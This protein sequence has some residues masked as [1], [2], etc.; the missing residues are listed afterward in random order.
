MRTKLFVL[1]A[2]M[3]GVAGI[4]QSE[5]YQWINTQHVCSTENAKWTEAD[6]SAWGEWTNSPST[7]FITFAACDISQDDVRKIR[8]N[9]GDPCYVK[10]RDLEIISPLSYLS[11][12]KGYQGMYVRDL[13]QFYWLAESDNYFPTTEHE[14][15]KHVAIPSDGGKASIIIGYDGSV[16]Y[17]EFGKLSGEGEFAWFTLSAQCAPVFDPN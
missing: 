4:A 15:R 5:D 11:Q 1:I 2:S 3:A 12:A 14:A 7:F 10:R 13:T 8:D 17:S 9:L 6:G 16:R